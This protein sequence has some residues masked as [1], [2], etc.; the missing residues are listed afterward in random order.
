MRQQV[1]QL[2]QLIIK[3]RAEYAIKVQ[4]KDRKIKLLQH[5]LATLD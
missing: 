2:E 4:D 1:R 5:E 3:L